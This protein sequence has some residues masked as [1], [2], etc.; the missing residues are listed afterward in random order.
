MQTG[1]EAILSPITYKELEH[2][3]M[4]MNNILLEQ[5]N[6]HHKDFLKNIAFP[7]D[8]NPFKL[9]TWHHD[10]NLSDHCPPIPIFEIQN[11]PNIKVTNIK[12]FI[13]DNDITNNIVKKA[14]EN[15]KADEENIKSGF[16]IKTASNNSLLP[17]FISK[18]LINKVNL[19]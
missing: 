5:T 9:K 12:D 14:L 1:G 11:K 2:R 18:D 8:F 15:Y 17:K 7:R 10:F 16:D 19:F 4:I 13:R 6:Q 3:K